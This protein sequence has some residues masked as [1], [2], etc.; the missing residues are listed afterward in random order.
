MK[1][2]GTLIV[3]IFFSC[4]FAFSQTYEEI[5]KLREQYDQLKQKTSIQLH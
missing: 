4:S 5:M 1:I 3:V 2:T